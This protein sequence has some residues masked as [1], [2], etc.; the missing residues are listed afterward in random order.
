VLGIGGLTARG[1]PVTWGTFTEECCEPARLGCRSFGTWV[2][3]IFVGHWAPTFFALSL[4]L[5]HEERDQ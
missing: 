2:S 1:E 4:A 3:G 5:K